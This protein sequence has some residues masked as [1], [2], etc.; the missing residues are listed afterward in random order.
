L[1]SVEV[2]PPRVRKPSSALICEVNMWTA[3]P[4]GASYFEISNVE[5]PELGSFRGNADVMY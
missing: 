2:P 1:D 5:D 4:A 3:C